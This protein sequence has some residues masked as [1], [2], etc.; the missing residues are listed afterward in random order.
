MLVQQKRTL[1]FIAM[2]A[3]L[4]SHRIWL[5]IARILGISTRCS[6]DPLAHKKE[7]D[8]AR[9]ALAKANEHFDYGVRNGLLQVPII[10]STA[11]TLTSARDLLAQTETENNEYLEQLNIPPASECTESTHTISTDADNDFP[12]RLDALFNFVARIQCPN[13]DNHVTT[14]TINNTSTT[15]PPILTTT[16]ATTPVSSS[17]ATRSHPIITCDN[18][19]CSRQELDRVYPCRLRRGHSCRNTTY[20]TATCRDADSTRHIQLHHQRPC[21]DNPDCDLKGA[22]AR[23]TPCTSCDLSRYCSIACR[24][25]DKPSHMLLHRPTKEPA[26]QIHQA[27]HHDAGHFNQAATRQPSQEP[28]PSTMTAAN[29]AQRANEPCRKHARGACR[30]NHCPFKHA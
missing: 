11:E 5:E 14:T 15:T 9:V 28:P 13:A 23:T 29:V 6:K 8:Y 24:D 22:R 10:E 3:P 27:R 4:R 26:P 17:P 21:C 19:G 1:T 25:A 20:C 30:L 16:A 7:I 18:P 12:Q 2:D